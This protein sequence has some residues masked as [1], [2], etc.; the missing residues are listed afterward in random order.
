MRAHPDEGTP[1]LSSPRSWALA[2]LEPRVW[3]LGGWG[4]GDPEAA[5]SRGCRALPR[6]TSFS[7]EGFPS[8]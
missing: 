7:G 1:L 4:R 6:T 5:S 3:A 2:P 8:Y